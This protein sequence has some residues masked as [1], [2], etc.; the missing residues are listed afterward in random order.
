MYNVK[1]T[2][3]YHLTLQFPSA[4]WSILASFSLVL[5]LQNLQFT[6][7]ALTNCFPAVFSQK[8]ALVTQMYATK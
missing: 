3:N 2:E 6:F 5:I 1:Q 4:L 8:K 7:N